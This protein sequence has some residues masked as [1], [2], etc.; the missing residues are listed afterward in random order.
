ML[1]LTEAPSAQKLT[2]GCV[3]DL[4]FKELATLQIAACRWPQHHT[5]ALGQES[6][7]RPG[8]RRKGRRGLC[9]PQRTVPFPP[10]SQP[11]PPK[12]RV[13]APEVRA[14]LPGKLFRPAWRKSLLPG[15]PGPPPP[16]HLPDL[17]NPMVL[18]WFAHS[19][20]GTP[21]PALHAPLSWDVSL[22]GGV[23]CRPAPSLHPQPPRVATS[24][25]LAFQPPRAWAGSRY[26]PYSPGLGQRGKGLSWAAAGR[27]HRGFGG[28]A[29]MKMP[30]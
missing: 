27:W 22:P 3:T 16:P 6:G 30:T 4:S 12:G 2:P 11:L 21:Q 17:T 23:L 25:F 29:S 8:S 28:C 14:A 20:P 19:L 9:F 10:Q 15:P 1:G 26:T 18:G 7:W 5:Q 13:G 24:P